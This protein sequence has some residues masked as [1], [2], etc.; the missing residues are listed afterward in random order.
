MIKE[1]TFLLEIFYN[2]GLQ[3]Y[4]FICLLILC[5]KSAHREVKL[6]DRIFAV[7]L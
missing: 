2:K 3:K 1:D 7:G 6:L 5:R 4:V